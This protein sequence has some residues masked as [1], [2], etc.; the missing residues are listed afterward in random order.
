MKKICVLFLWFTCSPSLFSQ[1]K[2]VEDDP[3]TSGFEGNTF[4]TT[5][6]DMFVIENGPIKEYLPQDVGNPSVPLDG[7]LT[8][9]LVAGGAAGYR[10][11]KKK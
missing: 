8:A 2:L 11:Y 10:Q 6:N 5:F 7:G 9:L 4:S 3:L 1:N